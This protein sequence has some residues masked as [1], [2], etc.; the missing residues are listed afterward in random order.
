MSFPAVS[1]ET[2]VTGKANELYFRG[3]SNHS[4]FICYNK[5]VLRLLPEVDWKK[6]TTKGCITVRHI[7]DYK[8]MEVKWDWKKFFIGFQVKLSANPSV[9][10]KLLSTIISIYDHLIW[11][12]FLYWNRGWYFSKY[13]ES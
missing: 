6:N 1:K 5:K 13:A 11:E 8:A 2:N 7:E 10:L 12:L 3:D 4:E 9:R